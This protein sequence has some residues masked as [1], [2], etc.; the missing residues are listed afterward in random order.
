MKVVLTHYGEHDIEWATAFSDDITVYDRTDGSRLPDTVHRIPRENF[1]DADFDR[2]SYL[3]DNYFD[4][5]D[6]FL[7]SKSNLFKFITPEEWDK[8]KDN[9]DFIPLLTQNHKTYSDKLGQVCFYQDGMYYERNDSWYLNELP[10]KYATYGDF[11]REFHLP[12]PSYLPFAPGGNY[13]LTKER[14]HRYGVDFYDRMRSILP[15][16]ERP[17]EAQCIERSLYTLW[18]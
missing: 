14:V 6:I 15:Y 18:K 4:L 8:V 17:G 2:L 5:P 13:I 9:K 7:L 12:N 16:C 11:A 3:V 1:G 10:C